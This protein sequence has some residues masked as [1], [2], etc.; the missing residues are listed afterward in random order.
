MSKHMKRLA[1]PRSIRIH[2][3]EYKWTTKPSPGPHANDESIPLLSIVRDYLKL[4]DIRKEGKKI[5]ADGEVMVDGA[6]RRDYRFPCG[7]MD[8][9]SVPK[10]QKHYRILYDGRG[11]LTLVP[12]SEMDAAW[13]LCRIQNKTTVSKGKTQLNLHDGRNILL[14]T[15]QY[16]TGDVLRLS[17]SDNKILDVYQFK[18]GTICAITGG[19]HIGEIAEI[20]EIEI[21]PSSKP[22]LAKMKG[23]TEFFTITPY[24]FPIGSTTPVVM[25]PEVTM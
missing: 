16:S 12:I 13:K 15:N 8:V 24:V 10:I 3:K 18:K 4:C 11:K 25:M 22:N 6:V 14:D 7:F 19:E 20:V 2:R 9:I 21:V 1:A 23:K 17:L 5:I